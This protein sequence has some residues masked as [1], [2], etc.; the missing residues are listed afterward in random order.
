MKAALESRGRTWLLHVSVLRPDDDIQLD[1]CFC[2]QAGCFVLAHL[3]LACK[4]SW[5]KALTAVLT[6]ACS[7]VWNYARTPRGKWI[8][9]CLGM[10][11]LAGSQV[12]WTW[13][14][15]DSFRRVSEGDKHA[16]KAYAAKLTDQLSQ[17]TGMVSVVVIGDDCRARCVAG[18]SLPQSF[19]QRTCCGPLM[20]GPL[21][22]Q[23]QVWPE[24]HTRP[25]P[26]L[27]PSSSC[28]QVRSELS[29][30]A[31][32]K[33]NTLIITD[34]HG[35]DII[36][37]FVRDSIM[38]AREFAWESQLRFYWDK[39]MVSQQQSNHL[40]CQHLPDPRAG[41]LGLH[42]GACCRSHL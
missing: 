41:L 7:G 40:L 34:V 19:R 23:L 2:D 25:P 32:R 20:S 5:Q 10:V 9:D 28:W 8:V 39:G 30:D 33:V 17:L 38:D 18:E 11:T 16:M 31:R 1:L 27:C 21:N 24:H 6:A 26:L 42:N 15:E 14:T 35:R 12:W 36:D 4:H 37:T 22:P 3:R 13:K 29:G